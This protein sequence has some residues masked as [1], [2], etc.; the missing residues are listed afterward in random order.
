MPLTGR[1][2]DTRHRD[3]QTRTAPSRSQAEPRERY[4]YQYE[5]TY[6]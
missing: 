4:T 5:R 3:I 2:L 6:R 1:T